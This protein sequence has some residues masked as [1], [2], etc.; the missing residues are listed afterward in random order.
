VADRAPGDRPVG[1]AQGAIE[2]PQERRSSNSGEVENVEP[3][4]ADTEQ[5]QAGSDEQTA[6]AR[7]AAAGERDAHARD[8]AAIARD[9]AADA[10]DIAMAQHDVPPESQ[11]TGAAALADTD[12][13]VRAAGRRKRA[14]QNPTRAADHRA[15][16]AQDRQSA[17]QD[18]ERAA[19]ERLRALADRETFA[20]Q[21][22]S[23]ATDTL[24]GTRARAAGLTDLDHE[25]DRCRRTDRPL[26]V[27]Y[28]DVVGL[29]ALD[30]SARASARDELLTRIVMLVNEHVRSYDLIVRLGDDELL[31]AMSNMTPADARR[32]FSAIDAALAAAPGPGA[33]RTGFAAL[34]P[35]DNATAL[36]A[37]ALTDLRADGGHSPRSAHEPTTIRTR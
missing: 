21:L 15:L 1:A 27:A 20:H 26:A 5:G 8:S 25:L 16:G 33:I 28:V 24:T 37:R 30:D 18:R 13:M 9:R 10:R 6:K 22:A 36:I 12:T 7:L 19:D 29:K 14:A 11:P 4:L 17:A 35:G 31:C 34:M 32:R 2:G 3:L 23:A